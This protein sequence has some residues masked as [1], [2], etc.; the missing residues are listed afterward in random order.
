MVFASHVAVIFVA[1]LLSLVAVALWGIIV[2]PWL[3]SQRPD[4]Q[5]C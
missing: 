1:A 5:P 3:E 2:R 4:G